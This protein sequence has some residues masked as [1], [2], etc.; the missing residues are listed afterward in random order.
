DLKADETGLL[1]LSR[2]EKLPILF[3]SKEELN[4]VTTVLT[5]SEAVRRAVGVRSVCEAAAILAAGN[6]ELVV[7]KQKR[8]NATVAVARTPCMSWASAPGRRHTSPGGR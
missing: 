4:S 8:R 5:P 6:G 3:F 1:A 2:E 7:P